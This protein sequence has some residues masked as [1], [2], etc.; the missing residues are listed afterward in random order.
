MKN[1]TIIKAKYIVESDRRKGKAVMCLDTGEVFTSATGKYPNLCTGDL[2]LEIDGE[3]ATF[4]YG[5]ESKEKP[6]Y[7]RFWS[8]G[9]GLNPNYDGAWQGE[10]K[11]DINDIPEQFRK[12]AT[13][14]NE[15]FNDNVE[16]GCCG[17][18]I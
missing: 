8:S 15:V 10:W 18:C 13:E 17:G 6:K 12:Y 1:I 2:T 3:I 16:W 14:I 9:G 11:I 5:F 7:H 4:G